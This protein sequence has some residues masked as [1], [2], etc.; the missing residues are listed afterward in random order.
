MNNKVTAIILAAGQ[1][2][3]MGQPKMLLPWGETT[4]LGQAIETIK[5]AGMENI[6]V[7][8]GGARR[9]VE[10]FVGE[11]ARVV[12]NMEYSRGEMLGSIQRGL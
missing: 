3:R 8:T 10:S 7:V 12:F 11:T 9:Q 5:A 2:R 6:V 1:S 4:V